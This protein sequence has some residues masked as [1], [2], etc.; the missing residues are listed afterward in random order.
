MPSPRET[1]KRDS[2]DSRGDETEGQ[3]RNENKNESEET[4]EIKHPPLP[5][6]AARIAGLV[7]L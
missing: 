7:Q 5:L 1:E 2:R 3:G 6:S 4:E